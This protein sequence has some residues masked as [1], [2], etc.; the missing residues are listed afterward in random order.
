MA[1]RNVQ[2][3][4][5]TVAPHL[6]IHVQ[7]AGAA[8]KQLTLVGKHSLENQAHKK[9]CVHHMHIRLTLPHAEQGTVFV[10][11]VTGPLL[12]YR[13]AAAQPCSAK[14]TSTE[15][16][17]VHKAMQRV[18]YEGSATE[19][20]TLTLSQHAAAHAASVQQQQRCP[21]LTMPAAS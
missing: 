14:G 12:C 1:W 2:L 3:L 20:I 13:G 5:K 9:P 10:C 11:Y 8:K 7:G 19:D 15:H 21:L 6:H 17:A 16:L 18:A 4:S